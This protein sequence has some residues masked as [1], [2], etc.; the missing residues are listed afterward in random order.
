[1]KPLR[2][3]ILVEGSGALSAQLVAGADREA[4]TIN[5]A[6]FRDALDRLRDDALDRR[7]GERE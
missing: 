7:S 4:R 6:Q 3:I 1:M 2:A 5:S